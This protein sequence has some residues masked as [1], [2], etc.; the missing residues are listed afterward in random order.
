M[1]TSYYTLC[2]FDDGVWHPQFGD[3]DHSV[4]EDERSEYYEGCGYSASRL[5]IVKSGVDQAAVD[6][7][8]AELNRRVKS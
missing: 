6:Q 2:T 7:A 4:V 8:V 5:K 1:K 3:Y